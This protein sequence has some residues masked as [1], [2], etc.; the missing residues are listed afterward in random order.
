[1]QKK[2]FL[3]PKIRFFIL[4]SVLLM[5]FF[6]CTSKTNQTAE[7]ITAQ[8]GTEMQNISREVTTLLPG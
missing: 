4:V 6:G 5:L 3:L 8:G 7:S 2:Y 1:M